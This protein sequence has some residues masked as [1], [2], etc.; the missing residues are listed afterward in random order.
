M[1]AS[2]QSKAASGENKIIVYPLTVKIRSVECAPSLQNEANEQ[3]QDTAILL[4]KN[5]DIA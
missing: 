3:M 2:L 5:D 1:R 4:R